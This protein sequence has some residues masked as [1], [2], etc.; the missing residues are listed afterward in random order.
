MGL[1]SS[2]A[3]SQLAISFSAISGASSFTAKANRLNVAV[4]RAQWAAFLVHSPSLRR[5]TPTSVPGLV[6]L[7]GF[8]GLLD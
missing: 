7:G 3:Q 6:N 4:S 1:L 2:T 8:L 5:L